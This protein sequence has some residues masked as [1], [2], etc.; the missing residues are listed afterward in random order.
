LKSLNVPQP[1][2]RRIMDARPGDFYFEGESGSIWVE[3]IAA[4]EV[5]VSDLSDFKRCLGASPAG[6][7]GRD[8]SRTGPHRI[9][10]CARAAAR[11]TFHT[12]SSTDLGGGE[13]SRGASF[14]FTAQLPTVVFPPALLQTILDLRSPQ[15][16][17]DPGARDRN[18]R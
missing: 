12:A 17:P 11:V 6:G 18:R 13:Y 7:K 5:V 9:W 14:A 8:R 2:D 1:I 15:S 16:D 10:H 4:D 3:G